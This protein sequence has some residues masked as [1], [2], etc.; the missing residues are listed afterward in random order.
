MV[1][2]TTNVKDAHDIASAIEGE[3]ER[4]LGDGDATAHI[5]PCG[6]CEVCKEE[7]KFRRD[8]ETK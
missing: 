8:T 5:E 7:T 6:G 2:A 3:I 1:P 4:A